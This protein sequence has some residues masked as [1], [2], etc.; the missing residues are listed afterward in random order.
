[1]KESTLKIVLPAA[2]LALA[3]AAIYW[4]SSPKGSRETGPPPP[5]AS[6]TP[7]G[8]SGDS[9]PSI[10]Q[11]KGTKPAV[12]VSQALVEPVAANALVRRKSSYE[13]ADERNPF[14]PIGWKPEEKSS[15]GGE[16][17]PA[18]SPTAFALSSVTIG[19]EHKF[20]ILNRKVLQEGQQFAF[21]LGQHLYQLTIKAVQDGRVILAYDGGEVTVAL[22]RQ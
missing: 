16:A 17:A 1:M 18:I 22:H 8:M 19:P 6:I 13:V 11:A 7:P 3:G 15:S 10:A 14:W 12:E 9:H 5:L 20:V 2:T 4:F 21:Q